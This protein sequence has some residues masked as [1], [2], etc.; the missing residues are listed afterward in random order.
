MG[1]RFSCTPCPRGLGRAAGDDARGED[2][3]C[4][5][6]PPRAT[7]P[8]RGGASAGDPLSDPRVKAALADIT[9]GGAPDRAKMEAY[10][11]DPLVGPGLRA[12]QAQQR[13]GGGAPPPELK[14][15]LIEELLL[16]ILR[17][18]SPWPF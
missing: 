11:A 10:M 16:S 7:T 3:V 5:P 17:L 9:S 12:L 13:G 14:T 6:M 8:P 15:S 1:W 18:F 4:E 2:T